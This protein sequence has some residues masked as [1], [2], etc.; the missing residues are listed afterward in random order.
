VLLLVVDAGVEQAASKESG[1]F[2][3]EE[4]ADLDRASVH[5]LEAT[6]ADEDIVVGRVVN[7]GRVRSHAVGGCFSVEVVDFFAFFVVSKAI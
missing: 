2:A 7:L 4:K 5:V 1:Q 6:S 3:V